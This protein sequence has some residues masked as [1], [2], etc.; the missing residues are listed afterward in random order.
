MIFVE[1]F[2]NYK[3]KLNRNLSKKSKNRK[4]QKRRD[5]FCMAVGNCVEYT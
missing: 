1:I 4:S 3:K 2:T 5:I